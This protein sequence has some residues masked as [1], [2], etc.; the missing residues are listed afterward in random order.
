MSLQKYAWHVFNVNATVQSWCCGWTWIMT[1]V[2]Q[3]QSCCQEVWTSQYSRK[4]AIYVRDFTWALLTVSGRSMSAASPKK[5]QKSSVLREGPVQHQTKRPKAR[6]DRP[7]KQFLALRPSRTKVK[8]AAHCTSVIW[9]GLSNIL[10]LLSTILMNFSRSEMLWGKLSWKNSAL[11]AQ[12]RRGWEID[13]QQVRILNHTGWAEGTP[14]NNE[15]SFPLSPFSVCVSCWVFSCE[16]PSSKALR[17]NKFPLLQV[18][19][20]HLPCWPCTW[21]ELSAGKHK[22]LFSL[23]RENKKWFVWSPG[24]CHPCLLQR[25]K[26]TSRLFPPACRSHILV[27]SLDW[28]GRQ[29][30]Y[31]QCGAP[32]SSWKAHA[33]LQ[34]FLVNL[35]WKIQG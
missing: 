18:Q 34:P 16:C 26:Q 35:E 17:R 29:L 27:S 31:F 9:P 10:L 24:L 1:L 8:A 20:V 14:M 30:P 2:K 6:P 25:V 19:N 13:T 23:C 5:L 32:G 21:E 28:G 15:A 3:F 22:H 12:N 7:Q 33:L 11:L 4:T